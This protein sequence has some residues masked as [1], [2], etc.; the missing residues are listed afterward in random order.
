MSERNDIKSLVG[1]LRT[2]ANALSVSGDVGAANSGRQLLVIA[3]ALEHLLGGVVVARNGAEPKP[4][5]VRHPKT[6]D[7]AGLNTAPPT[8]KTSDAPGLVL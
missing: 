2:E 4:K 6:N 5:R 1:D 7:A 8:V 3:T